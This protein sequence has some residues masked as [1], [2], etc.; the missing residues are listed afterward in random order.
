MDW[1]NAYSGNPNGDVARTYYTIK[2]GLAP[3]DEETLNKSFIHRFFFKTLKKL[4]ARTYIK[5]YLKLTGRSRKEI[6]KWDLVIFAARLSEPVSLEYDNLLK[7]IHKKLK[8][9]K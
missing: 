4:V 6:K 7:M 9:L 8:H 3:S 1:T 2:Y 5:Q